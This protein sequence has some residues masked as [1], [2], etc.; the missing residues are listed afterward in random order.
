MIIL[1]QNYIINNYIICNIVVLLNLRSMQIFAFLKIQIIPQDLEK[2]HRLKLRNIIIL[3]KNI[4]NSMLQ[5]NL[6]VYNNHNITMII[7]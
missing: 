4:S 7:F 5:N 1:I 2:K 3:E 6:R